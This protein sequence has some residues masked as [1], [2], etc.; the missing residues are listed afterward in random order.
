MA[1]V[2][3]RMCLVAITLTRLCEQNQRCGVGCLK[4]ECK[5]KKNNFLGLCLIVLQYQC[6]G[7]GVGSKGHHFGR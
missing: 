7:W 4:A 1:R 2:G 3:I 5:I 6:K